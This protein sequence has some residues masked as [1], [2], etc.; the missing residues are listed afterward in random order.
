MK[1]SWRTLETLPELGIDVLVLERG[2]PKIAS[3]ALYLPTS[4]DTWFWDDHRDDGG[5][6]DII[7]ADV[8]HWQPLEGPEK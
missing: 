8:T 1:D 6:S 4:R 5:G 3:R 2:Q 7:D